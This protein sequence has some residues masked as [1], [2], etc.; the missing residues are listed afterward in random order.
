[1]YF[2]E[3]PSELVLNDI[4][5]PLVIALPSRLISLSHSRVNLVG[6]CSPR[7]PARNL[8]NSWD[9]TYR[10]VDTSKHAL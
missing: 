3:N 4:L 9:S 8:A 5:S 6:S 2:V 10:F 1:M 7:T